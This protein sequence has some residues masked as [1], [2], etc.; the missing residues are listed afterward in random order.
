MPRDRRL[1]AS[2][3]SAHPGA[4]R[5]DGLHILVVDDDADGRT[6]T[7][8]VLT[9]LGARVN[10]VASAQ[11]ARQ[12]LS[13]QRPDV[14]VS[15]IGMPGE[16]GYS[17]I[18]QIRQH[19]AERGGFLPAIAVTGYA[20]DEERSR[21]LGAGFQAH[22]PKPLVPAELTAAITRVARADYGSIET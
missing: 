2:L 22:V 1:G 5:L 19:E 13:V 7:S 11:E 4:E 9:D 21:A 16:D 12:M 3:G 15:D 20:G 18:R 6:L 10:A 8:L 17:L 14:L